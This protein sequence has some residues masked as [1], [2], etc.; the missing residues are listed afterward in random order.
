MPPSYH[1]IPIERHMMRISS[2]VSSISALFLVTFLFQEELTW[3]VKGTDILK[4]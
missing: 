2:T 4:L 3:A 1:L